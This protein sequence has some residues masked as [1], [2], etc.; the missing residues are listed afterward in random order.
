MLNLE[1]N[2]VLELQERIYEV[3]SKQ[4]YELCTVEKCIAFQNSATEIYRKLYFCLLLIGLHFISQ[5]NASQ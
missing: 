2:V 4:V 1:M 5:G 3:N